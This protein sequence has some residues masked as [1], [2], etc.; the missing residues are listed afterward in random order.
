MVIQLNA[1]LLK[2]AIVLSERRNFSQAAE[3]LGV[4]QPTFSKQIIALENELGIKLF[5]RNKSPLE[6]TPAGEYFIGKA[7]EM[8]YAEDQLQKT[9]E[10]FQS[11]E[12]GRL[13]IGVTPF[14]SMSLMPEL[15]KKVKARYPGVKV[16]LHEA[17]AMQLRKD[18]AEG[19]CDFVI[20]N[21]P[22]DDS[23]LEVTPIE[24]DTL[25]L[26]VP[27]SLVSKL[28]QPEMMSG[29]TIELAQAKDLPFVT[30]GQ[31]QEL[32]QLLDK[33]CAANG[34]YPN[35]TAE[36][37]GITTA[38]AMARAGVGA[39]LLPLQLAEMENT[40]ESLRLYPLKK[41]IYSRQP[42]VVTRR[43]QYMSEYAAYAINLLKK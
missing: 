13:V 25:V 38:W 26:A 11:G 39:V 42:A 36:V 33:L 2:Y 16:V 32:R 9:L 15:V 14:R 6:L 17:N 43:G 7:R 19:K 34:F 21:L 29:E 8:L 27:N 18:A 24:P 31:R 40:D 41:G 23:L 22:V 35:I 37:V 1:R 3:Q 12:N 30:L 20:L 28:E 10:Q 4:S 5:D